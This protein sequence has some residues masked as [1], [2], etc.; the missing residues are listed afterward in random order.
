MEKKKRE[1]GFLLP[2][3][4][5]NL[6]TVFYCLEKHIVQAKNIY[7]ICTG[8]LILNIYFRNYVST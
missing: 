3:M 2:M 7:Q 5:A 6:K 1:E 4:F 8:L